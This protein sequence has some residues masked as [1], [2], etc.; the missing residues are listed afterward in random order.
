MLLLLVLLL[1]LLPLLL[2]LLLALLLMLPLLPTNVLPAATRP[3]SPRSAHSSDPCAT[4]A[5]C[6]TSSAIRCNAATSTPGS[7]RQAP[8]T[9]V[10]LLGHNPRHA[11]L[12]QPRCAT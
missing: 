2:L 12:V 9:H 4:P 10:L 6:H 5:A 8:G 11:R 7:E 1:L 3:L